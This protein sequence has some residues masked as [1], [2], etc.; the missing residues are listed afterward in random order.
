[1]R[2]VDRETPISRYQRRHIDREY[3]HQGLARGTRGQDLPLDLTTSGRRSP[4]GLSHLSDL[5]NKDNRIPFKWLKASYSEPS[6]PGSPQFSA[7]WPLC[8]CQGWG[9]ILSPTQGN[10]APSGFFRVTPACSLLVVISD[11]RSYADFYKLGFQGQP[12]PFGDPIDLEQYWDGVQDS[13]RAAP[14]GQYT[15]PSGKKEGVYYGRSIKPRRTYKPHRNN[16]SFS[17]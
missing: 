7:Q 10:P 2:I 8:H 17:C 1:M 16:G 5:S 3:S 14:L 12:V 15:P 4:T 13:N 9:V 11:P 6:G